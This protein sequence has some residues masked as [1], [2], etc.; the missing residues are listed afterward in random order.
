[1]S[2]WVGTANNWLVRSHARKKEERTDLSSDLGFVTE[3]AED[4]EIGVQNK[5]NAT[6]NQ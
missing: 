2:E 1:M 4:F 5:I 3:R 6:M